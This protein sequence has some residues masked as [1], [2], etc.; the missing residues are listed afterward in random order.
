MVKINPK[1]QKENYEYLFTRAF[2]IAS[3][4][5][6]NLNYNKLYLL[7]DG[8]ATINIAKEFRDKKS[9]TKRFSLFKGKNKRE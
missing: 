9:L 4:F 5:V 1:A 8:N 3:Y 6:N 7:D 2:P